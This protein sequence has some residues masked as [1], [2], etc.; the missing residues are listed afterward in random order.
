MS[1]YCCCAPPSL[2]LMWWMHSSSSMSI[3]QSSVFAEMTE[4]PTLIFPMTRP[5]RMSAFVLPYVNTPFSRMKNLKRESQYDYEQL[6]LSQSLMDVW[7][8]MSS[9][10]S[11]VE[12]PTHTCTRQLFNI[13]KLSNKCLYLLND[14]WSILGANHLLCHPFS[15]HFLRLAKNPSSFFGLM[16]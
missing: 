3:R 15:G 11:E 12:V 14:L 2:T 1:T 9:N 13:F 8:K 10:R 7:P 6:C 16:L 4:S 5:R